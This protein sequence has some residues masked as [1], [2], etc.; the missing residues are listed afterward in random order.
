MN[1]I[2]EKRARVRA[3]TRSLERV[4]AGVLAQGSPK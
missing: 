3:C 1:Q 2:N 4:P